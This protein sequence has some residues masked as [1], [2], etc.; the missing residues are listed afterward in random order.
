[1]KK[2]LIALTASALFAFSA[3]AQEL[4]MVDIPG[5]D[6][7]MLKTEVTQELYE[8]VM[9]VNP[10]RFQ[11]GRELFGKEYKITAGENIKRLP[12]ENV[13]WFDAIYFLKSSE[14]KTK[15]L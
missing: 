1:M 6:F 11:P 14:E 13:S 5:Q 15:N 9:G 4:D 10:S 12:V 3:S 2:L 8:E 7:K